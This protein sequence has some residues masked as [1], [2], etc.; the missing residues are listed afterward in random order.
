MTSSGQIGAYQTVQATTADPGQ[1][2][3]LLFDGAVRFLTRARRQLQAGDLAPF[4]QSVARTQAIL[5]ELRTSLDHEKGGEMAETLEQLYA[6][7]QLHLTQGLVTR[8]IAHLDQVL[9]PLQTVRE[10]FHAAV[11]GETA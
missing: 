3:L 9:R 1:L 8:N 6:F 2:L 11:A 5:A 4:A 7:M 10:G